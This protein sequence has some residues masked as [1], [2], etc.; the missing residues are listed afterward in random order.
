M[1][2]WLE[3]LDTVSRILLD[4]KS[5]SWPTRQE[6]VCRIGGLDNPGDLTLL[7]E[8]AAAEKWFIR[9]M[10]AAGIRSIRDLGMADPLRTGLSSRDEILRTACARSLGSMGIST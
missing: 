2:S 10:I 3:N 7:I 4:L 9:E 5:D 6:A 1:Q 8:K